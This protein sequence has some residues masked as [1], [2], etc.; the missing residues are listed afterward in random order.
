MVVDLESER[1][2]ALEC[3]NPGITALCLVD[4]QSNHQQLQLGGVGLVLSRAAFAYP[5][6]L[7]DAA[8]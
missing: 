3:A 6:I 7:R 8:C 4:A 5:G 1:I 2:Q